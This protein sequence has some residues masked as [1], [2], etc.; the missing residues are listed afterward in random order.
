MGYTTEKDEVARL[1][2]FVGGSDVGHRRKKEV[3]K[4]LA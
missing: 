3:K 2:A 1:V 4:L